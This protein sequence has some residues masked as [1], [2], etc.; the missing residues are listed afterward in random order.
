MAVVNSRQNA[1]IKAYVVQEE[2]AILLESA[3]ERDA[4]LAIFVSKEAHS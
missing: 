2:P 1:S 4:V 3:D